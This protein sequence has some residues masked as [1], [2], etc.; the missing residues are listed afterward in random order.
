MN[1]YSMNVIP[2][3]YIY[4]FDLC[5]LINRVKQNIKKSNLALSKLEWITML[6]CP[7]FNDILSHFV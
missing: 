2:I 1:V 3:Y 7:S 4:H 6:F 5:R